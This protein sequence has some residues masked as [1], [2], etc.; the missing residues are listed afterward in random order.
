MKNVIN[1]INSNN[2]RYIGELKD[3]LRIP[4]ISTT[5]KHK[6]D[7]IKSADDVAKK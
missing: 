3:F 7:M 5:P 2:N 1:Y 4:S 6:K